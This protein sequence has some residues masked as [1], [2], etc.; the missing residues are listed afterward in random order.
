M[1]KIGIIGG[2]PAGLSIAKLLSEKGVETTVFEAQDRIGGKSLSVNVS[3]NVI[4]M[5]TC[6]T[7]LAYK[8]IHKWMNELNI[9]MK[10]MKD[11]TYD[12]KPF[13][14]FIN[15]TNGTPLPLQVL[16]FLKLKNKLFKKYETNK[17]NQEVLDELALPALEWLRK[18]NLTKIERM[19]Y[20]SQT[21]MGYGK[22]DEVSIYQALLWHSLGLFVSGKMNSLK[23][24]VLGWENF[25]QELSK[26]LNVKINSKV[27][28][29]ERSPNGVSLT[30]T[31]GE[32]HDFDE[33]IVTI[34]MDD[35]IKTT[36]PTESE[37][38]VTNSIEWNQYT[39]TIFSMKN[40]FN[41][42]AFKGYSKGVLP[43]SKQGH[44]IGA[45]FEGY[46]N[47][48]KANLYLGAQITKGLTETEAQK[49]L[50]DDIKEITGNNIEDIIVQQ[51]WKYFPM[52]KKESI[53]NGLPLVMENMQGENN[54]W[55]SGATFSFESVNNIVNFNTLL[56][57]KILK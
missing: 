18:H 48:R 49:I 41:H 16:K 9:E 34:P 44:L 8:I 6:Y 35:F 50:N 3:G 54:T 30:L 57:K 29:T 12:D 14:K 11:T 17:E 10:D 55:Y 40:W 46:D 47:E 25:W 23:L 1:K 20:R 33:I 19:M 37:K 53:K 51:N 52:F 7:T 28:N 39:T 13:P 43:N 4:E 5:G 32:H 42:Y 21:A 24:P 15:D 22:L 38:F 45:R 26:D 2:G 27:S 36:T 56:V 31:N